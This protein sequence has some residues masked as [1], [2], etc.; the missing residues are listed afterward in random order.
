[1]EFGAKVYE[2][3]QKANAANN[4]EAKEETK[5]DDDDVIDAKF[6]E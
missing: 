2:E 5:K 3:A 4:T 1:M 6:E